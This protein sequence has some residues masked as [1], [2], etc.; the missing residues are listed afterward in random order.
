[1]SE[2]VLFLNFNFAFFL[3]T[4]EL[5]HINSSLME[6]VK[7]FPLK[8]V[9]SDKVGAKDNKIISNQGIGSYFFVWE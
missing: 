1:M 4:N 7:A 5:A 9:W 6:N 3:T 2:I 8:K